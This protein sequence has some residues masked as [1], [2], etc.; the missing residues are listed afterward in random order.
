MRLEVDL[1]FASAPERKPTTD[2]IRSLD[3]ATIASELR[4]GQRLWRRLREQRYDVVKVR[5]DERPPSAVQ[6]SCLVCIAAIPAGRFE[7]ARRELSPARFLLRA[8]GKA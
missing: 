8:L 3:L 5:E 4:S 7:V 1:R 6:A 2:D